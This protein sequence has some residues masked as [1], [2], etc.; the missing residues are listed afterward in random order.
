MQLAC[1]S[2]DSW[3]GPVP[4]ARAGKGQGAWLGKGPEAPPPVLSC[5]HSPGH[6]LSGS[7]APLPCD[8]FEG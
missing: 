1:P 7:M 5:L 8:F 6:C 3:L 2:W 4:E